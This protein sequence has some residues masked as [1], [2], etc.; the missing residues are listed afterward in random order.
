MFKDIIQLIK[1]VF[2]AHICD[3]TC[4]LVIKVSIVFLSTFVQINNKF[5]CVNIV[6]SELIIQ[7][8][9]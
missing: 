5:K 8:T 2:K 3:K 1:N 9:V 4:F 6:C 7:L